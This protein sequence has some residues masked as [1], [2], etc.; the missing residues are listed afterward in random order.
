M[1]KILDGIHDHT[2]QAQVTWENRRMSHGIP[3][4]ADKGLNLAINL[5]DLERVAPQVRE[6]L[7]GHGLLLLDPA[8]IW[9][10]RS[11][12]EETGLAFACNLMQ[13]AA[14]CDIL[15][16]HDRKVGQPPTRVYLRKVKAWTK[17]AGDAILVLYG[18]LNPTVFPPE[19]AVVV[20][21]SFP[22]RARKI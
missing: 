10:D 12:I 4:P 14:I 6:E 22:T 11:N 20:A 8:P 5:V 17:L 13:A 18:K 21:P 16:G 3:G 15:R 19:R 2:E 9:I 1:P 7:F